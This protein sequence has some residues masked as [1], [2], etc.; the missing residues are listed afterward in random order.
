[1]I[2]EVSTMKSIVS[3]YYYTLADLAV[4]TGER[5]FVDYA[6][7]LDLFLWSLIPEDRR[8]DS[9]NFVEIKNSDAGTV[10]NNYIWPRFRENVFI[11]VDVEAKPWWTYEPDEEP[12]DEDVKEACLKK[13]GQV[14]AWFRESI[15]RYT[16]II[17]TLEE[18]KTKLLDQIESS[19]VSVYNDTPQV[20]NDFENDPYATTSTRSKSKSEV[21]TPIERFNEINKK[22]RSVYED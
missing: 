21:A 11:Y 2:K 4:I 15:E 6:P 20:A 5:D 18:V 19:A 10:W 13:V 3:R 14:Y 17:Q 22:M 1:M 7:E 9:A 16:P 8:D 12:S